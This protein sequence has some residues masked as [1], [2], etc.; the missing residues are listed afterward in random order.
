MPCSRACAYA[1]N[2][3]SR[4]KGKKRGRVGSGRSGVRVISTTAL[5]SWSISHSNTNH[6]RARLPAEFVGGKWGRDKYSTPLL[7]PLSL[8]VDK[9]RSDVRGVSRSVNTVL[10]CGPDFRIRFGLVQSVRFRSLH[11]YGV[12]RTSRADTATTHKCQDVFAPHEVVLM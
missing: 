6:T 8:A 5:S 9:T 12:L 3:S 11:W 7:P 10:N 4:A 2:G 1:V